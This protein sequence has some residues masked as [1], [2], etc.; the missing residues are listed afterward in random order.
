MAPDHSE[1]LQCV[2]ER[3]AVNSFLYLNVTSSNVLYSDI[4]PLHFLGRGEQLWNEMAR[5]RGH[6]FSSEKEIRRELYEQVC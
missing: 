3:N 2:Y 4:F 6:I 5:N 1:E